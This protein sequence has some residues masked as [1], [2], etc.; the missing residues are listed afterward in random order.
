MSKTHIYQP[1][2]GDMIDLFSSE[3][4][5]PDDEKHFVDDPERVYSWSLQLLPEDEMREIAVHLS[6]CDYC[7]SEIL[8][9]LQLGVL[10]PEIH[11]DS[12]QIEAAFGDNLEVKN[13]PASHPR[14]S[15]RHGEMKDRP[16]SVRFYARPRFSSALSVCCII[17]ILGAFLYGTHR[18]GG[19]F[20]GWNE[21]RPENT[22]SNT[23][24][25]QATQEQERQQPQEGQI[26]VDVRRGNN[27]DS[28]S[29]QPSMSSRQIIE[30]ASVPKPVAELWRV[31][32]NVLLNPNV[33]REK[34]LEVFLTVLGSDVS[35]DDRITVGQFLMKNGLFDEAKALFRKILESDSGSKNVEATIGLGWILYA[36]KKYQ[37]AYETFS[38][39]PELDDDTLKS[40]VEYNAA[41]AA[42][43][44]REPQT[45]E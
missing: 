35:N 5:Q 41:E 26:R 18:F 36:E 11:T 17:V 37:K 34:L 30:S 21:G 15:V 14:S 3:E 16:A 33:D 7:Q 2:F 22:D 42:K 12:S 39:L 40:I 27:G 45:Q 28:N 25:P 23:G 13:Q 1:L 4:G 38:S 31:E 19:N 32:E 9:M 43:M 6:G 29:H 44:C 10:G 20:I 24:F 8:E